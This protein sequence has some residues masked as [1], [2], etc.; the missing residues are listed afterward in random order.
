[1]SVKNRIPELKNRNLV[2]RLAEGQREID[3]ANQLVCQNYLR[4]GLF[5]D[6]AVFWENAYIHSPF[7]TAIVAMDNE[8]V[9]GTVSIIKDSPLGL[10]A[11]KFQPDIVRQL[12][13]RGELLAESSAFSVDPGQD[14]RS[15]AL[16][17]L[18]FM[19]QYGFYHVGID[20]FLASVVPK[21]G[22]FYQNV[23]R[24]IKLSEATHNA[25]VQRDGELLSLAFL[26]AHQ[27]LYEHY[28]RD[29]GNH[30]NF[31]RF[32]MLDD[33]PAMMFPDNKG[34]RRRKA[35]YWRREAA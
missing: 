12:R 16:F 29:A 25:Y 30:S 21:H 19:F 5:Q 6:E 26:Q 11:D 35:Q 3:Q 9:V 31:Y 34:L 24:F 2:I 15:L 33:H 27:D 32:V 1:M 28:E 23:F 18:T 13:A 22:N 20:R 10:P 4:V 8:Q 7:R 14:Q 17:L